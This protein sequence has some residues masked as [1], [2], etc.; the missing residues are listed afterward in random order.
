MT[1]RPPGPKVA[2]LGAELRTVRKRLSMT[3]AEV[4]ERLG[5]SEATMSRLETGR[6]S[7]DT[8]DVSAVL[9]IYGVTGT[10]RD[11]LMA[12]ARTPDEP[13][14]LEIDLPGVPKDTGKLATYEANSSRLTDW[15]PLLV[16]GLLQT[17]EYSRAFMLGD[18][19]PE[20]EIGARL[21]ARQR[22]Q[23]QLINVEY[24]A[25]VAESVLGRPIGGRKV[26]RDQLRRMIDLVE[27]RSATIHVVPCTHDAHGGLMSPFLLLE[28]DSV[29]PRVHV[30]L[31]RSA[32]FL[33]GEH[34]VA[35]YLA[36]VQRLHAISYG[37]EESLR[38]LC[39]A[40]AVIE[41]EA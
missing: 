32:V 19:I 13:N 8:E 21:M 11:R 24:T 26:M 38:A 41:T 20:R 9:A 10:D 33:T 18:G 3:M 34:E 4:A 35:A 23:E 40:A 12:M 37:V 1:R 16:P 17:M 14:W 29:M 28:F 36:I 30:E 22:R 25:Y 15:S 39:T 27:E 6:R 5:W 2:G 7:I 31:A